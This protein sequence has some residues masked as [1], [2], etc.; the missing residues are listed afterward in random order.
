MPRKWAQHE[1]GGKPV[2]DWQT[3]QNN[4][5]IEGEVSRVYRCASKWIS[6]AQQRARDFGDKEAEM[7]KYLTGKLELT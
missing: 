1:R 7:C 3:D 5:G 2:V 6:M 4:R